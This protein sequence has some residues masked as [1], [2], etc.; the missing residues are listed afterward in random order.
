MDNKKNKKQDT[1]AGLISGLLRL[2]MVGGAYYFYK[3]SKESYAKTQSM[4]DSIQSEFLNVNT[5]NKANKSAVNNFYKTFYEKGSP[6]LFNERLKMALSNT[7]YRNDTIPSISSIEQFKN[8]MADKPSAYQ[9]LGHHTRNA[10]FPFTPSQINNELGS[11]RISVPKTAEISTENFFKTY[12]A[13]LNLS[14]KEQEFFKSKIEE[15]KK[16]SGSKKVRI[17]PI[18]TG[19]EKKVRSASILFTNMS[20]KKKREYILDF[21]NDNKVF[22]GDNSTDKAIARLF[23]EV[24]SSEAMSLP[25]TQLEAY[26]RYP[27]LNPKELR[28]RLLQKNVYDPNE[29]PNLEM[30]STDEYFKKNEIVYYSAEE[31]DIKFGVR[32]AKAPGMAVSKKSIHS[33]LSPEITH[34]YPAAIGY[35]NPRQ[36]FGYTKMFDP[37]GKLTRKAPKVMRKT[38]HD[39]LGT[40]DA[41][42]GA[43]DTFHIRVASI[44]QKIL[45]Q[46]VER[47]IF[48][49]SLMKVS[50]DQVIWSNTMQ[51]LQQLTPTPV[52]V[53]LLAGGEIENLLQ[54]VY[55]KSILESNQAISFNDWLTTNADEYLQ[56]NP[57]QIQKKTLV[58]LNRQ[59]GN[60][61]LKKNTY[62]TGLSISNEK[63]YLKYKFQTLKSD[64]LKSGLKIFG[65]DSKKTAYFA[66]QQEVRAA[67]RYGTA[68]TYAL[69]NVGKNVDKDF[70]RIF[71]TISKTNPTAIGLKRFKETG[72]FKHLIAAA[73]NNKFLGSKD[74]ELLDTLSGTQKYLGVEHKRFDVDEIRAI[75]SNK[76]I[77][78]YKTIDKIN[79]LVQDAEI[80]AAIHAKKDPSFI[81]PLKKI[82]YVMQEDGMLL[83]EG[84]TRD[85]LALYNDLENIIGPNTSNMILSNQQVGLGHKS[86]MLGF[87][88]RATIGRPVWEGLAD[89]NTSQDYKNL[90]EDIF[91]R[92]EGYSDDIKSLVQEYISMTVPSKSSEYIDFKEFIDNKNKYFPEEVA[93]RKPLLIRM[94]GTGSKAVVIPSTLFQ[95]GL[96][97]DKRGI[98]IHGEIHKSFSNLIDIAEKYQESPSQYKDLFE[99]TYK[100][101]ISKYGEIIQGLANDRAIGGK[102]DGFQAQVRG[103]V[104]RAGEMKKIRKAL[105]SNKAFRE[106]ISRHFGENLLPVLENP[107]MEK[108][109]I[110]GSNT[111]I[112][113]LTKEARLNGEPIPKSIAAYGSK[114]PNYRGSTLQGMVINTSDFLT[115]AKKHAILDYN[116]NLGEETVGIS[117]EIKKATFLDEDQDPLHM[118]SPHQEKNQSL[119]YS[120]IQDPNSK[121]NQLMEISEKQAVLLSSSA[122][123]PLKVGDIYDELTGKM[124]PVFIEQRLNEF[125]VSFG[126]IGIAHNAAE[127]IRDAASGMKNK[128]G[129]IIGSSTKLIQEKILKTASK[130]NTGIEQVN[131]LINEMK[132]LSQGKK[133]LPAFLGAM[134]VLFDTEN[135]TQDQKIAYNE[136]RTAFGT[137][138]FEDELIKRGEVLERMKNISSLED[139][140][141]N[142]GKGVSNKT[143]NYI[144]DIAK[145]AAPDLGKASPADAIKDVAS[146]ASGTLGDLFN[147][148]TALIAGGIALA[149]STLGGSTPM[150]VPQDSDNPI[151]QVPPRA[152]K[153]V[154]PPRQS[155]GYSNMNT[156]VNLE[157]RINSSRLSEFLSGVESTVGNLRIDSRLD[158]ITPESI[159]DM[160]TDEKSNTWNHNR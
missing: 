44:N 45:D 67:A 97:I 47:G 23:Q 124:N 105:T 120:Q 121:Y 119:I 13:K 62:I 53:N 109:I 27:E 28:K 152:G 89:I 145:T 41:V 11:V 31:N 159:R 122:K 17:V 118:F 134:D 99:D 52:E 104:L 15:L 127:V 147:K 143:L 135:L 56:S 36:T 25:M 32:P 22:M 96:Y 95:G 34:S 83:Y 157:A 132:S 60:I 64:S 5:S 1:S 86:E 153:A 9:Y 141:A 21:V 117:E 71:N 103:K 149:A 72:L 77:A 29:N 6:E 54:G 160:V 113:A 93:K 139:L 59:E 102:V 130:G 101:H 115:I 125:D 142:V 70:Y 112:D 58:G 39:A 123:P 78:G 75:D 61:V 148:R 84:K 79:A 68:M 55:K 136:I 150:K 37:K 14:A 146:Q 110:E 20:D 73:K 108:H 16:Q 131:S 35:K 69:E 46:A 100:S 49:N 2:G 126:K 129:L 138:G 91:P 155:I 128:E 7:S 114:Y 158:A 38:V 98:E 156:D 111:I 57:L 137:T 4:I 50:G 76:G 154:L 106:E 82:G 88:N 26:T 66:R 10:N 8:Y 151:T 80:R 116:V 18:L 87:G 30:S 51:A 74:Y 144:A 65:F 63:G 43:T 19:D 140:V 24:N 107:S 40:I 12:G 42:H 33:E 133:N 85:P 3:K 92:V 90:V 48:G 81:D 94:P